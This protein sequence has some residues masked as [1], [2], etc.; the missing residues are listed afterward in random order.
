M[1]LRGSWSDTVWFSLF[2]EIGHILLHDK[3]VTFLEN[4]KLDPQYQKQERS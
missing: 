2:H 4:G 3:R 1:S